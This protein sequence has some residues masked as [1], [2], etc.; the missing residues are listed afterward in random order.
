MTGYKRRA[1][2][3]MFHFFNIFVQSGAMFNLFKKFLVLKIAERVQQLS[4]LKCEGCQAGFLLD[5]L[6]I[7]MMKTLEH[8]IELFLPKAK[9][10]ALERLEVLFNLFKMSSWI[11]LNQN[12]I[13]DGGDFIQEISLRH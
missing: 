11:D 6:H 7:C 9:A 13:G 8:K 2:L 3:E 12:Y 10:E 5:Q 1:S 4:Q